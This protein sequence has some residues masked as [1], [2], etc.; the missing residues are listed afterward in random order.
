MSKMK[1]Y[2]GG[3]LL[4]IGILANEMEEKCRTF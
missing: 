2:Y 1:D 3:S 4:L